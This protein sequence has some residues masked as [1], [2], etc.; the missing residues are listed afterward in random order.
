V[1]APPPESLPFGGGSHVSVA[2]TQYSPG[3]QSEFTRQLSPAPPPAQR[4]PGAAMTI[5]AASA[6][7][8]AAPTKP[9][10]CMAVF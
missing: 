4:H 7:A 8:G 9:N 1:A 10:L 2:G 5:A 6:A 3:S